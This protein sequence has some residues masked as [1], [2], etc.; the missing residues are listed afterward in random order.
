M[1][2]P[3]A[4]D[5]LLMSHNRVAKI[6]PLLGLVKIDFS[7]PY[8]STILEIATFFTLRYW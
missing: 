8:G 4:V 6:S 5:F 1:S 2:D 7:I 3:T